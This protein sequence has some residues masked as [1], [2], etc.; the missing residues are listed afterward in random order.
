MV[1]NKE[2]WMTAL[3]GCII[4][5]LLIGLAIGLHAG[6]QSAIDKNASCYLSHDE[7]M[8][9]KLLWD[10]EYKNV[11]CDENLWVCENKLL[12]CASDKLDLM[13]KDISNVEVPVSNESNHTVFDTENIYFNS[14]ISAVNIT[15]G[16][17]VSFMTLNAT[18][19]VHYAN[20]SVGDL[21]MSNLLY[22][23]RNVTWVFVVQ[24]NI[25]NFRYKMIPCIVVEDV[26][27]YCEGLD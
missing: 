26:F 10:A 16:L 19:M 1:F 23:G 8:S 7:K 15:Q 25:D 24:K 17:N 9:Y 11:I 14:T 21:N 27:E 18:S 12:D 5:S 6:E 2:Q 4:I 3:V 22:E 20:R 13:V